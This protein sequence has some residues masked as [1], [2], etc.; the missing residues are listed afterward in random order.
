MR[1]RQIIAYL[2]ISADGF[3]AR[4]DGDVAWLD[5]PRTAGDYGMGAFYKTIDTVVM[6]R[7]TFEVGR[8]LGQESYAGKKNYVFSRRWRGRQ[9]A[10]VE[11]VAGPLR[12]FARGLRG[13]PG[14]DIWLVGG[15]ALVGAFLDEGQLDQ[16]IIHVIPTLIGEGI[17][18][19]QPRHRLVPLQLRSS[20]RY[21]D[22]VV[23]LHYDV[24]PQASRGSR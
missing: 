8:R 17:P 4:P 7:K 12:S 3:I 9:V 11:I 13:R 2:A 22:G 21:R 19:L 15:A 16:L 10:N 5:R 14:K 24:E 1:R 20:R 6:G 23:R 18:L